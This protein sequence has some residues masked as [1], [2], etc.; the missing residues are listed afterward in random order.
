[1]HG[2]RKSEIKIQADGIGRQASDFTGLTDS[3]ALINLSLFE[4]AF[5]AWKVQIVRNKTITAPLI[6]KVLLLKNC[7]LLND[8]IKNPSAGIIKTAIKG[9]R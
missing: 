9:I 2:T 4:I 7:F 8:A 1:M 6:T 3:R 5:S